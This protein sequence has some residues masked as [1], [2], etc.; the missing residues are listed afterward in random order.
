MGQ[1]RDEGNAAHRGG[2]A[3]R[4]APEID[5]C[6]R[7]ED[8]AEV[9]RCRGRA[10]DGGRWSVFEEA[11]SECEP[12]RDVAWGHEAVMPDFDEAFRQDVKKEAPEEFVWRERRGLFAARAERD[13]TL[14]ERHES[15]V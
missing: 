5:A 10:G 2:A 8:L 13:A 11:A 6:E 12:G 4:T 15:A 1:R 14:V 9:A 7:E 3:A